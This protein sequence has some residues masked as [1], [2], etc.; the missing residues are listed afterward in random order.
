MTPMSKVVATLLAGVLGIG[1][2]MGQSQ[3]ASPG[4]RPTDKISADL[5]IP[6]AVFVA[7]FSRVLQEKN[8]SQSGIQQRVNKAILLLC[9]QKSKSS[10][11]T[12][13]LDTVIDSY[14]PAGPNHG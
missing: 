3:T 13:R 2:A 8:H 14:R 11:T 12:E 7:C 10:T 9:L 1:F 6:E 4:Q 5:D